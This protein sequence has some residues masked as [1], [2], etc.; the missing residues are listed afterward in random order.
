MLKKVRIML[1]LLIFVYA[2]NVFTFSAFADSMDDYIVTSGVFD[3]IVLTDDSIALTGYSGDETDVVI[4]HTID[5]KVISEIAESAF[6]DNDK[7]TSITFNDGV[8][9]LKSGCF[10]N[11]TALKTVNVGEGLLDIGDECFYNCTSLEEFYIPSITIFLGK[12]AFVNCT[13]L[14]KIELPNTL[15]KIGEHS[16][17]Y[18]KDEKSGEYTKS[19]DFVIICVVNSLG[20]KYANENGISYEDGE[21]RSDLDTLNPNNSS[22]TAEKSN[23]VPSLLS[24][25]ENVSGSNLSANKAYIF[26]GVGIVVLFA[27]AG[28]VYSKIKK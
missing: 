9:Y 19:D 11:C 10:R 25:A 17:G 22:S 3:Y 24:N 26:L 23:E 20:H 18:T 4:P 1:F 15:M 14:K 7:I 6:S 5:G 8:K 13:S 27:A 16:V 12:D 21:I 2:V 28:V